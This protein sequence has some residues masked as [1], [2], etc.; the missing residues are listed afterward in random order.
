VL[1][2]LA[3]LRGRRTVVLVSHQPDVVAVADRVVRVGEHEDED[4]YVHE[5]EDEYEAQN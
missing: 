3:C 1:D 4:E 2:A 5:Y